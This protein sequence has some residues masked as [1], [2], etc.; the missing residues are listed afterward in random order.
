VESVTSRP[1]P[2]V[3]RRPRRTSVPEWPLGASLR[4]VRRRIRRGGR[5]RGVAARSAPRAVR[6]AAQPGAGLAPPAS[7]RL[8][9]GRLR[10]PGARPLGAGPALAFALEHPEGAPALVRLTP[11][12]TRDGRSG[13]HESWGRLAAE[14]EPAPG[15]LPGGAARRR[16]Q[17]RREAAR[18]ST[19]HR[20]ERHEHAQAASSI[21][22]VRRSGG[23]TPSCGGEVEGQDAGSGASGCAGRSDARTCT[24][25]P[26]SGNGISTR[27]KSRGTITRSGGP[28]NAARASSR[29]SPPA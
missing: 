23:A 5:R 13:A 29:S 27:S 2:A 14:L 7:P 12:Y 19:R 15:R 3:W 6:D 16:P 18:Q 9:P 8:S 1:R 4:D 17:R 26:R 25:S 11:A 20:I 28:L 21:T 22:S 10:R 24:G